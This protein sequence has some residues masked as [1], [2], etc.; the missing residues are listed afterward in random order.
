MSNWCHRH[1]LGLVGSFLQSIIFVVY[2]AVIPCEAEIGA[3]TLFAHGAVGTVIHPKS[4]IGKRVLITQGV[5]IGGKSLHSD[6]VPTIGDDVYIGAGAKIL[7]NIHVGDDSLIGAN[8]VVVKSVPPG[9]MVVGVPAIIKRVGIK[10]RDFE[11]W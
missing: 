11:S 3:G 8:A 2:N 9:S 1:G 7:G 4:K 6:G 5:T 10:A